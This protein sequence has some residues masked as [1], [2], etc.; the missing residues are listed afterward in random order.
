MSIRSICIQLQDLSVS[1]SSMFNLYKHIRFLAGR[2]FT[3]TERHKAVIEL[4]PFIFPNV[5]MVLHPL[6][7]WFP[8]KCGLGYNKNTAR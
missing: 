3:L 6:A 8:P 4:Q 5:T 1:I 2:E 7:F